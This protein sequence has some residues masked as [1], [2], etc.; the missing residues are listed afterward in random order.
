MSNTNART[1]LAT[2]HDVTAID[3]KQAS[4]IAT[5]LKARFPN[6]CNQQQALEVARVALSYSLDPFLGELIP[7]Q[8]AP[9]VTIAGRFRVADNNPMFDGYDI[10]P[11][12]EQEYRAL[13][14]HEAE[15]VWKCIVYRKDRKRP[16]V[17][18]G[19][20]GGP[21]ETNP[22][23][24]RWTAEVAQKRAIHRALRAAF[25]M[26]IP[27]LEES[28]TPEQLRA[29]HAAD[30]EYGIERDERHH[31]LVETFDVE[32][33][34]ELTSG[35]ASVYLDE[36]KVTAHV[37]VDA[38]GVIVESDSPVDEYADI[39]RSE[40]LIDLKSATDRRDLSGLKARIRAASLADDPQ[41]KSAY[42]AAYQRLRGAQEPTG[43]DQPALD[44]IA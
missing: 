37:E 34:K 1:E 5:R 6:D 18:W 40:I 33:S 29:I 32:S 14:A 43:D 11:A 8:G 21:Q 12:T 16:T 38:D 42:N 31:T 35:Q 41:V 3:E 24:K 9:Y 7:Y 27:G 30:N 25:P 36:R 19:R 39:E 23:A 17:A 13:R 4:A 44:G 2:I 28:L 10:E 20:A 15:S 26:P 22:V